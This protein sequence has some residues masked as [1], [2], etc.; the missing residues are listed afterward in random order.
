[1]NLINRN[2][3]Y[4]LPEIKTPKD[5]WQY[6]ASFNNIEFYETDIN[7]VVLNTIFQN[8][9]FVDKLEVAT[10][11]INTNEIKYD[12]FLFIGIPNDHGIDVDGLAGLYANVVESLM[13]KNY[14]N[15]LKNYIKCD[16][17]VQFNNIKP[18]Y[19]TTKYTKSTNTTGVEISYSIWI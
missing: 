5:I 6:I 17:E 9:F 8:F 1:M 12:G 18:L 14:I 16:Y 11:R 3:N 15:S 19:N 2:T 10:P 13:A 7:G 4:I